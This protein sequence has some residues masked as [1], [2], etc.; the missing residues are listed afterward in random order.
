MKEK[1]IENNNKCNCGDKKCVIN[2]KK[3]FT[4]LMLKK[5]HPI[6][7]NFHVDTDERTE[8]QFHNPERLYNYNKIFKFKKC[9]LYIE[10]VCLCESYKKIMDKIIPILDR[11]EQA[12]IDL[13]ADKKKYEK[14]WKK[15]EKQIFTNVKTNQINKF[16]N[17][18][19]KNLK[20]KL[21][22]LEYENYKLKYDDSS[23]NNSENSIDNEEEETEQQIN[24]NNELDKLELINKFQSLDN[25]LYDRNC[26]INDF[27]NTKNYNE[28]E[29]NTLKNKFF[30]LRQ[31][32]N[33]IAH[34]EAKN[35]DEYEFIK[36][37][38]D[39]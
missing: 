16:L 2:N 11:Q 20:R 23:D 31:L 25:F 21:K 32:R 10:Y 13:T 12:G 35:I 39:I 7:T 5:E 27:I 1:E 18:E 9:D 38:K 15:Y 19:N 34:P 6:F 3:Y 33:Q 37:L 14:L 17:D 29:K 4:S 28:E 26:K 22:K 30:K 8:F 36:I 24:L